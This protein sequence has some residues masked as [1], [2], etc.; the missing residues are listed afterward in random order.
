MRF[1]FICFLNRE[2]LAAVEG[3][4]STSSV[5]TPLLAPTQRRCVLVV[6][7]PWP[8]GVPP[9]TNKPDRFYRARNTPGA[10]LLTASHFCFI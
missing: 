4:I 2:L 10:V 6:P 3:S 8:A 1:M 7:L 9:K 5:P